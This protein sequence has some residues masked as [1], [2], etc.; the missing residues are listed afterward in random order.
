LS[1]L[2]CTKTG[3]QDIVPEKGDVFAHFLS[4]MDFVSTPVSGHYYEPTTQMTQTQGF[5][6]D[7]NVALRNMFQESISNGR[8]HWRTSSP[9]VHCFDFLLRLFVFLFIAIFN[10]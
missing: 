8:A 5:G 6:K 3:E 4:A 10:N 9:R 1:S 7:S 2:S